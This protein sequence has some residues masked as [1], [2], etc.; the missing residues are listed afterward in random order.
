M[1][2][3]ISKSRV[4]SGHQLEQQRQTAEDCRGWSRHPAG[5]REREGQLS[6]RFLSGV[7]IAVRHRG[8]LPHGHGGTVAAVQP[9]KHAATRQ[10]EALL[11]AQH[12][13]DTDVQQRQHSVMIWHRN[14]FQTRRIFDPTKLLCQ[15][16]SEN[17]SDLLNPWMWSPMSV[18]KMKF[19]C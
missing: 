16:I 19:L 5:W 11:H 3:I 7:E 12:T 17:I 10:V 4:L 9:G 15:I 8:V 18:L 13:G 14:N 6:R 1:N 2:G